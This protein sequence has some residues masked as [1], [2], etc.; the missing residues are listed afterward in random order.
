MGRDSENLV[1][2]GVTTVS[3]RGTSSI[4]TDVLST[5]EIKRRS[6]SGTK[7]L[8]LMNGLGM[9][10]A[11]LIALMLGRI[12]PE[13]LG[14]YAI[15]QILIG[16]ITT[17]VVYGG[18]PVL[19]VF[20]PKLASAE[21]RGRFVFSYLVILLVFMVAIL[22]LFWLFPKLLAF[23]LRREFSMHSYGWFIAL[24][25]AIVATETFANAASGLM[26]IKVTAIARQM[27]R[28][29]L[30]P[31][32][33]ILFF[34][35]RDL[36]IEHAMPFILGGFLGGYV[37]AA[38][39]AFIGIHRDGRF[40]LHRGWLL[41]RGFWAFSSVAMASTI[42]TFFYG[43]FDR[44]AVLSIQD[45]EGLGRYQAV[46]SVNAFI[47]HIPALVVPS[48]IPTFSNL[49]AAGREETF[50][51]AFV[52]LCRWAVVPVTVVSLITMGF[53]HTLLS[54]F[55]A[56]YAEYYWLLTLFGLTAIVRSLNLVTSTIN[57]C[58][59]HNTF[60]FVQQLSMILI[61]CVLTLALISAYGV[62]AIA[63]AKMISVAIASVSGV[64]Y[65]F[66]IIGMS[67]KLP[68][69]YKAAVLVGIAMTILRIGVVPT[70]LMAAS[71]LTL[72]CLIAFVGI[73]RFSWEEARGFVRFVLGHDVGIVIRM[74]QRDL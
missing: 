51:R 70:S 59:E 3:S 33:A 16:V 56:T 65:I 14:V 49:L 68:L 44:M 57:T 35:R 62:I 64:L 9:P 30:L 47:E 11:F 55:G 21:D 19:S 60:R 39:I 31:L 28:T 54:V 45:L 25:L 13:A 61:Q 66:F 6:I 69:S 1:V 53:S 15:V 73:S 72:S 22:V 27:M 63:G 18:P 40:S 12:G 34:F 36:L 24:A 52:L 41:P 38:V 37:A 42:F 7:W 58:M 48:L 32:V 23:L 4:S 46:L 74:A 67:R 29:V 17:F 2:A 8:V 10:T 20:L 5:S 43:N 26:L 50:K 71:C